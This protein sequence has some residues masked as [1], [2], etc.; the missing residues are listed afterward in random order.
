MLDD[1]KAQVAV[2]AR[3]AERNGLCT[4]GVGNFSAIDRKSG[5]IAITRSGCPW[6]R[7]T[8]EDIL[9]IDMAGR[10]VESWQTECREMEGIIAEGEMTASECA[11][12]VGSPTEYKPAEG[13]TT[14]NGMLAGKASKRP[15]REYLM[16]ISAYQTRSEILSVAHTHSPYATAFA[17]LGKTIEPVSF[18]AAFYG[19]K[20]SVA[21]LASPGSAELAEL[22]RIPLVEADVCLLR[23]HGLITVGK[24]AASAVLKAKYVERVAKVYYLVLSQR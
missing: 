20:V 23:N 24:S 11:A 18:E 7:V 5:L 22:I 21:G 13:E 17:V 1:L 10:V 14:E 9:L 2:A 8:V 6:E 15:S 12:V 4:K 16:H 3:E 19:N